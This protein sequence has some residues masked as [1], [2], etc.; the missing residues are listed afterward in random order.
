VNGKEQ[1]SKD[2]RAV[3]IFTGLA[4]HE[5]EQIAEVCS[6]RTYQDGERCAVQGEKIDELRIVREGKVAI[7]IR[8]QVAPSPQT[9]RI[10]ILTAGNAFAYCSVT[11]PHIV[12]ASGKCLGQAQIISIKASD[13][14]RIFKERPS[15]ERVVMKNMATVM[16]SRLRDNLTQLMRLVA[17][18]MP[19]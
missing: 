18:M 7:E 5:L 13:L 16:A 12:F 8:I 19:K 6:L 4:S 14:Q 3:D 15:I 11:E 1:L 10:A 2:L 17:E 9:L